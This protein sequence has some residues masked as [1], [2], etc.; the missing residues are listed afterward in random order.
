MDMNIMYDIIEAKN[1]ENV[2]FYQLNLVSI[3]IRSLLVYVSLT[4]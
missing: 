3:W 2:Y 4:R 1:E